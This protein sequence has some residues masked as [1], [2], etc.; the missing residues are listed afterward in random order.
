MRE[1]A[2]LEKQELL[3]IQ[4]QEQ[5]RQINRLSLQQEQEKQQAEQQI[6]RLRAT[7]QELGQRIVDLKQIA[8]SSAFNQ[9]EQTQRVLER[10]NEELLLARQNKAE[11]DEKITD[12]NQHIE[13]FQQQLQTAYEREQETKRLERELK[14]A[15]EQRDGLQFE[16]EQ[17]QVHQNQ[18]LQAT[19]QQ[20]EKIQLLAE[21]IEKYQQKLLLA[22][23]QESEVERLRRGIEAAEAQRT[24][25]QVSLER[26]RQLEDEALNEIKVLEQRLGDKE[27]IS[28]Q[29]EQQIQQLEADL[30]EFKDQEDDAIKK[31]KAAS[32]EIERLKQ[33]NERITEDL[34][35][36][37]LNR[38][39]QEIR[40][41]LSRDLTDSRVVPQF[42]TTRHGTS[43]FTDFVVSMRHCIVL[44]EAKSYSG[45]IQSRNPRNG[46][47][48]CQFNA[49]RVLINACW[50]DNPYH[51]VKNCGDAFRAQHHAFR[52]E[53]KMPTYGVVVF[54]KDARI[55]QEVSASINS[56]G[57]FQR[58]ITLNNLITTLQ[59]LDNEAR[60]R[61]RSGLT[62]RRVLDQIVVQR[63]TARA[64]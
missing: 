1:R 55:S 20:D 16:V 4:L 35:P 54:P 48:Y 62:G 9:D 47:W 32:D 18:A 46:V 22:Q 12:L 39:E 29:L 52:S 49:E 30:Q 58:V 31:A 21:Q 33:E 56:S 36:H 3:A 40:N 64:A 19:K 5:I 60:W 7:N 44:I 37:P 63:P 43:M 24:E 57:S 8:S 27:N 2:L 41:L 61:N 25:V 28:R 45:L 59:E 23:N 17:S 14:A 6:E 50:G 53:K 51:Q 34:G 15:T 10:V 38:F 13:Q 26:S 11:Q 42:D